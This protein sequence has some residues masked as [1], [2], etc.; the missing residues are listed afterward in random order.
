MSPDRTHL[1][2]VGTG[3]TQARR[4]RQRA[5]IRHAAH[6]LAAF[7]GSSATDVDDA[8]RAAE[9]A[10]RAAVSSGAGLERVSAELEVSVRALRAIVDGTVPLRSLHP[11]A[12]LRTS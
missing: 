9:T 5:S 11:D 12:R 6:R 2:D 4:E 1:L 8:S 3:D 10:L 7:V